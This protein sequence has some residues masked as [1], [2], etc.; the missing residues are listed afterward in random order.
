MLAGLD[1]VNI[2]TNDLD[3]CRAFYCGI[4]GFEEGFRPNIAREGIWLYRNGQPLLHILKYDEEVPQ[5]SGALDHVAFVAH[6]FEAFV[7]NLDKHGVAY[8]E[9][10]LAQIEVYQVF[11][12]DPHGIKI[13]ANF[14][15]DD[16][17][18]KIR[19]AAAG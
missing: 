6:E 7:A 12:H 13:E 16:R 19:E 11:F 9:S 2:S 15:G 4:L 3:A 8:Q 10:N 5:G 18:R 14:I 1:H 17:P